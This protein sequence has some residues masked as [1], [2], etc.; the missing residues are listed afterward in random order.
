[1][2]HFLTVKRF[3]GLKALEVVMFKSNPPRRFSVVLF[4]ADE[5]TGK[6]C[7]YTS[8][9]QEETGINMVILTVVQDCME[10]EKAHQNQCL[11]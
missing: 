11:F 8:D 10:F 1:M 2:P 9:I 4:S 5:K 3:F 6:T 7:K